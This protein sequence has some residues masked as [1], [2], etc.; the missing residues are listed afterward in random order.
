MAATRTPLL[1]AS[2]EEPTHVAR[3][4]PEPEPPSLTSLLGD[5]ESAPIASVSLTP[6]TAPIVAP[7]VMLQPLA[8][9]RGLA[10]I[11]VGMGLAIVALVVVGVKLVG[12]QK[13]TARRVE[14]ARAAPA[15]TPAV[16]VVEAPL[17]PP[18]PGARTPRTAPA[19]APARVAAV[20]PAPVP[21]AHAAVEKRAA[22]D[23]RAKAHH[24]REPRAR[25]VA[26]RT[27]VAKRSAAPPPAER[28]D[29][30]P[31]YERGNALLLAG[32]GKAAITA[33][34]EA[35]KS[36]PSEPIGFRGL[37]LAYEQQGETAAAI[38]ALRRYLKLAPAAPD[39]EI[40]SRR[41]DRLSKRAKQK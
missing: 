4:K 18:A 33:Y 20:K 22:G 1:T 38:R 13:T 6:D 17:P 10:L 25:K 21:Q 8:P 39:H 40:I 11:G 37:G 36:A 16:S 32:D 35:V 23:H 24:R 5:S 14:V 30:R 31:A 19:K 27:P 28:T 34:R 29:P 41:I 15:P 26:L 9:R 7:A 2:D 12:G 3:P